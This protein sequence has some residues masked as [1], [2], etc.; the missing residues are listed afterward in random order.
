MKRKMFFNNRSCCPKQR[1]V[2]H[3]NEIKKKED[4]VIPRPV[5]HGIL[6]VSQ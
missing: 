5:S 2:D 1:H 6:V 4:T 3:G